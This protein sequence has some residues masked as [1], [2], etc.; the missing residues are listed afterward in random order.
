M[1]TKGPGTDEETGNG[2]WTLVEVF[3]A[4]SYGESVAAFVQV[5]LQA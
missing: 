3:D 1:K 2:A 5:V 4:E